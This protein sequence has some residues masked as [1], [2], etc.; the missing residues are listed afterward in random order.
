ML[1]M[2]LFVDP[3]LKFLKQVNEL[4][5]VLAKQGNFT[6]PVR[7]AI[8]ELRNVFG[9]T[10]HKA[11]EVLTRHVKVRQPSRRCQDFADRP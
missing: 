3:R 10:L 9:D 5:Q 11:V 2:L 8:S 1:T 7:N 6:L 4:L